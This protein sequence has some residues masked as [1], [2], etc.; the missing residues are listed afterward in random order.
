MVGPSTGENPDRFSVPWNVD[1]SV[2][3]APD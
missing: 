1:Q 2:K 3:E